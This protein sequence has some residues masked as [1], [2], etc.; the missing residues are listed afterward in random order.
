MTSTTDLDLARDA[1]ARRAWSAAARVVCGRRRAG[2]LGALDLGQ[3][4]WRRT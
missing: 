2:S 3:A 4:G 1:F